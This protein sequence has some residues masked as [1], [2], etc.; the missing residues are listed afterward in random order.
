MAGHIKNQYYSFNVDSYGKKTFCSTKSGKVLFTLIPLYEF[1]LQI[2]DEEY[3]GIITSHQCEVKII[4]NESVYCTRYHHDLFDMDVCYTLE[5]DA[6]YKRMYLVARKD[7]VLR[8]AQTEV[9]RTFSTLSRGGEGQPVFLEDTAFISIMFPGAQN[10]IDGNIIRLEQSPYL[11][12]KAEEKFEFFPIV[13]GFSTEQSVEKS[14]LQYIVKHKKKTPTGLKIYSDWGAHDELAHEAML[15]EKMGLRLLEHLKK[16]KEAGVDFDYYLMDAQWFDEKGLYLS[17]KKWAWPN[18]AECFLKELKSMGMRFGMWFDVNMGML[19]LPESAVRYGGDDNRICLSYQENAKLLFDG[20]RA[21]IAQSECAMLKLDF[22]FFDCQGEGHDTHAAET[23]SSK[24]PAMR[25]F[26]KGLTDLYEENPDLIVLGYNGFT[27]DLKYIASVDKN[28]TG[29]A[30][31]PWWCLYLDYLYCGDPRP[32]EIPSEKIW[33]SMIYYTDSMINSFSKALMPY[34]AID[35]HGTMIGNTNT[36][37]YLGKQGFKNSWMMNISRGQKRM[38]LY[39]ELELLQKEDWQFVK[40]SQEMFDFICRSDVHTE[41]ILGEPQKG[42]P[43][44]YSNCNGDGGYFT[45][46]NPG[47]T[48]QDVLIK[49][50]EWQSGEIVSVRKYYAEEDFVHNDYQPSTGMKMVKLSANE[51]SIYQW[52]KAES[53]NGSREGYILMEPDGRE[54]LSLSGES[55]VL[56]LQLS[57]EYASPVRMYGRTVPV[58]LECLNE[59][60]SVERILEKPIWSG[61]SWAVYRINGTAKEQEKVDIRLSNRSGQYLHVKW[62]EKYHDAI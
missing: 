15:D 42:Q 44:G 11:T 7:I 10:N 59:N 18:G 31:S 27:T 38:L 36:I 57:D 54:I 26:L 28:H 29:Y 56:S 4:D 21:Q 49:L 32:S 58:E 47:N 50:P 13:Y 16:A 53:D 60:I 20:I 55:N 61:C 24:E 52:K 45:L 1:A 46:V 5:E 39:G 19:E 3:K 62:E 22:A 17:F 25:I 30:I 12:L 8:Y 34:V 51:I 2:E 6:V 9:S 41:T 35:D 14:F 48:E 40:K 37:Y 33:N 43:Y 23:V